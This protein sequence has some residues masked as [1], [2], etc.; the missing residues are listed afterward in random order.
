MTLFPF[1]QSSPTP[2]SSALSRMT[3]SPSSGFPTPS[4]FGE[5]ELPFSAPP[6]EV[7]VMK[8]L[9]AEGEADLEKLREAT[10]FGTG[11]LLSI[12]M[13]LELKSLVER[14]NDQRYRPTR[15]GRTR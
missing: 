12:L 9:N 3:C 13:T 8:V 15:G 7:A 6:A 5:A 14:G 2:L 1:T 11:D 4:G 10:G